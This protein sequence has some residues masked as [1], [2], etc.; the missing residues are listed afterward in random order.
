MEATVN[1][2]D[3]FVLLDKRKLETFKDCNERKRKL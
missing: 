3:D 1:T 2:K